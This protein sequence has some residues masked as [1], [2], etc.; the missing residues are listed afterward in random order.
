MINLRHILAQNARLILTD[1]GGLQK[2]AYW[3]GVPCVTL[4]N[5]TEGVETIEAGWNV[6]AG[7]DRAKIVA[8]A[9]TFDPPAARPALYGG[10]SSVVGEI[11]TILHSV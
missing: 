7:A 1:S 3:L 5:E 9:R 10:G 11:V 6:I 8:A 2:E 4:R